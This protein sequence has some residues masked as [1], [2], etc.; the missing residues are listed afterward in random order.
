MSNLDPADKCYSY[1]REVGATPEV[2][3]QA[4]EWS[5]RDTICVD[6]CIAETVKHLWDRGFV[7]EG[8]CCGH[9]FVPPSLVV[10]GDISEVARLKEAIKEVDRRYFTIQQWKLV[11]L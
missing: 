1:N 7:T 2:V 6:A 4:P 11:T 8:S 3:L 9:G 5:S 10:S